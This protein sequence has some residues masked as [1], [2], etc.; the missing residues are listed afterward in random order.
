MA[1]P[2]IA[3]LAAL[4]IQANPALRPSGTACNEC[5]DGVL[6]SSMH[7]PF[8]TLLHAHAHDWNVP[9]PD[10]D[11]G[12]GLTEAYPLLAAAAGKP[13]TGGPAYPS[14]AVRTGHLAQSTQAVWPIK[15]TDP[16]KAV[17]IVLT[18]PTSWDPYDGPFWMLHVH[19]AAGRTVALQ[20]GCWWDGQVLEGWCVPPGV[21]RTV[22]VSFTPAAAGNYFLD[23]TA[24]TMNA[25]YTLDFDG[26]AAVGTAAVPIKLQTT[27]A[28][29]GGAP[30][31]VSVTLGAAPSA[32]TSVHLAG[33]SSLN[34]PSQ[35][36]TFNSS[37]WNVPQT[38]PVGAVDDNVAQGPHG[39]RLTA[40]VTSGTPFAQVVSSPPVSL[41]I[42][43][44]D[45]AWNTPHV[46][47]V[48]LKAGNHESFGDALVESALAARSPPTAPSSCGTAKPSTSCPVRTM[49]S[50]PTSSCGICAPAPPPE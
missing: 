9:G 15:V 44:N 20:L 32:T 48:S 28:T 41:P 2:V 4:A 21:T 19:D 37:N 10:Y 27:T 30:A 8:T 22:D 34:V 11:T 38:L 50:R 5:A 49:A 31:Q 1:T 29:E 36:L 6:D 45:V 43:D 26:A 42:A 33:D 24:G 25:N 16:T 3:G 47:R 40:V 46:E 7:T 17:A 23:V 13:V 18:L 12:W 14:H 35:V 39:G